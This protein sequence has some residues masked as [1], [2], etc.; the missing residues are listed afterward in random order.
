L[1]EE[2]KNL[3]NKLQ[4]SQKR[5]NEARLKI[6]QDFENEKSALT[7]DYSRLIREARAKES[8]AQKTEIQNYQNLMSDRLENEKKVFLALETFTKNYRF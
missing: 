8:L 7:K 1:K 3:E 2:K 5:Q 4:E 6:E